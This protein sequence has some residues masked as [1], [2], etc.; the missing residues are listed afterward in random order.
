MTNETR[1]DQ[2]LERGADGAKDV[3]GHRLMWALLALVLLGLGLLAVAFFASR[4]ESEGTESALRGDVAALASQVR[5]LGGTPVVVPSAVVG[6]PGASGRDG[7]DGRDGKDGVPGRDGTSP[8]CLAEPPQC[9]G[10]DGTNGSDATGVP[11]QSGKD[12][13]DGK[14]GQDG[15]T[16][17]D[18]TDGR[19]PAGWRWVDSAGREQS[20]TRDPASPDTAPTYT[21]TAEPPTPTTTTTPT[22]TGLP[23]L[24]EPAR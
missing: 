15:A 23:L 22:G 14:D 8:P 20:C 7:I 12:G 3:T 1:V 16:G 11:G 21:C 2:A 4:A 5:G 6:A 13:A 17:A 19:P 10:K 24:P 9:Q 18:G